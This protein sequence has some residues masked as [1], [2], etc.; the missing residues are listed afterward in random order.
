MV[1]KAKYIGQSMPDVMTKNELY[2][3]SEWIILF[4]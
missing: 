2:E 4:N 1:Y 3:F